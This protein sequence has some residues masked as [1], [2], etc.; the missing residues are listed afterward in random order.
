MG[1]CEAELAYRPPFHVLCVVSCYACA[2]P[3]RSRWCAGSQ[4]CQLS[5]W[6]QS[7]NPKLFNPPGGVVDADSWAQAILAMNASYAV[8]TAKHNC[9]FIS[10]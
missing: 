2:L 3:S 8:F 1:P 7:S 5:N 4:G 6:E 10:W 9:G